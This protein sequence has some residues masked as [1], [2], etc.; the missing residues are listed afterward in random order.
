[1]MGNRRRLIVVGA[2]QQ[3]LGKIVALL[4]LHYCNQDVAMGCVLL[5]KTTQIIVERVIMCVVQ[6][7]IQVQL[8]VVAEFV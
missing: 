3:V 7:V 4:I 1:M 6:H 2:L 5:Y 8:Y